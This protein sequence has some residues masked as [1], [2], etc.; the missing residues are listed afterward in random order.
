VNNLLKQRA[1]IH[2]GIAEAFFVPTNRGDWTAIE[3]FIADVRGWEAGLRRLIDGGE[4]KQEEN[5]RSLLRLLRVA[6]SVQPACPKGASI[7]FSDPVGLTTAR[8]AIFAEGAK[9]KT[10][11]DRHF[12][13]GWQLW[14]EWLA[15]F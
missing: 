6:E 2:R 8:E 11:Q 12:Q 10:G 7:L 9:R 1:T 14:H 4:P 3:L 15:S 13:G 5:L